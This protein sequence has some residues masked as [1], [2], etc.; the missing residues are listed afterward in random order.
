MNTHFS[1]SQKFA[2]IHLQL[3]IPKRIL[4]AL[5]RTVRYSSLAHLEDHEAMMQKVNR[6]PWNSQKYFSK[7]IKEIEQAACNGVENALSTGSKNKLC[8]I[9]VAARFKLS[10]DFQ[11]CP[12]SFITRNMTAPTVLIQQNP[13]IKCF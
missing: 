1:F 4:V 6:Y 11:P 5:R 13:Q 8:R 9:R 7:T 3:T 12:K 10:K 2:V